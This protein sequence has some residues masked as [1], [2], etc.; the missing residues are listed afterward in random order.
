[1]DKAKII[2]IFISFLLFLLIILSVVRSPCKPHCSGAFCGPTSDD[3]CG[4]TCECDTD[5]KCIKNAQNL[6][7]CCYPNCNG[8]HYGD[9]GCGG[10][11]KCDAIPG[12]VNMNGKCC[13]KQDCNNVYCGP[14]GCGGTCGCQHGATCSDQGIC[15]NSGVS[16]WKWNIMQSNGIERSN[17]NSPE[18]CAGWMPENVALNLTNF[19]CSKSADCP[20]GDTCEK[21]FCNRNDV[22]QWWHYDPS[23]PSGYNCTK[24]RQ[25]SDVC[26]IPTTGASGFDIIGN[27]GPDKSACTGQCT[28]QP[29][30]PKSGAG[31]CCPEEWGAQS[32]NSSKC[33]DNSGTV[34]CCLNNPETT[35][36]KE[37]LNEHHPSCESLTNVW[38]KANLGQITNGQ[39]DMKVNGP[40]IGLNKTTLQNT[41]FVSACSD[42]NGGDSC[43]YNDGSTNYTGI[44][45]PC[46]DGTLKCLPENMCIA[47][48][49]SANQPGRCSSGSVC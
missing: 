19:P 37:C 14:D 9:D 43:D 47:N 34:K 40:S 1:M 21:G 28:I 30:C 8:L 44:C 6:Y 25:G 3:G 24:I 22:Y 46:S 2:G 48:Y 16:G 10:T 12:G 36:Y 45:K 35:D 27:Q 11:C 33:I 32:E 7:V 4:G 29:L 5:G 49:V 41:N 18:E 26:G 15:S 31:S 42:K 20:Y 13:Y 17:V 39:C 23:D 38:W